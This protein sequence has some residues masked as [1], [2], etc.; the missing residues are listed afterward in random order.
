MNKDVIILGKGCKYS[1]DSKETGLNNNVAVIGSTGSG[2]TCSVIIP[3]LLNTYDSNLILTD[4]KG[5]LIAKFAPMFKERG[6]K[7]LE[8][9]FNEPAK[10]KL[11][12]DPTAYIETDSDIS[13]LA[14]ALSSI[15]PDGHNSDKFWT[16]S[17]KMMVELLLRYSLKFVNDCNFHDF[18]KISR[19]VRAVTTGEFAGLDISSRLDDFARIYPDDGMSICY[20]NLKDIAP[21]T[22]ASILISFRAVFSTVFSPEIIDMFEKARTLD[23]DRFVKNKSVLF[24]TADGQNEGT[25]AFLN[26]V[27]DNILRA[28]MK[29]ADEFSGGVLPHPVHIIMDDFACGACIKNFPQMITTFRSKGISSSIILQDKNQLESMYGMSA[30][31]T[32]MNNNDTVV[33]LGGND[34]DTASDFSRRLN[35]PLEDVLY[36]PVNRVLIFR[37]GQQPIISERYP[38]FEDIEFKRVISGTKPESRVLDAADAL[39]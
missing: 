7:V 25:N 22:L 15:L 27:Y 32:I 3:R 34:I 8:I 23:I 21:R 24:I 2:K 26:F 17:S 5:E 10:S 28:L 20:N 33:Y 16:Y 4:P 9:N 18:L 6:Y 13:K 35:V 36:M 30:A 29:K 37:R 11:C 12:F 39:K 14:D 19:E 31:K 1:T 38:I